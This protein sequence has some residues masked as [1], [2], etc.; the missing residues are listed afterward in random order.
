MTT[1]PDTTQMN[2][3][4]EIQSTTI[5]FDIETGSQ[6]ADILADQIPAFDPAEV[7]TGN[8]KDPALIA[9]KVEQAREKH[10]ADFFAKAA[11]SPAT[12]TVVA[13]GIVVISNGQAQGFTIKFAD[14]DEAATIDTLWELYRAHYGKNVTFVGHNILDFDLPFLVNRSRILGLNLPPRLF[15]YKGGRIYWNDIFVDTRVLWLLGRKPTDTVS[16]LDHCA[17]AFGLGKKTGSGADFA[18]LAIEDRPAASEYL[19]Q[20]LSLTLKLATRLGAL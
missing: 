3:T 11:L 12:G 18:R 14:G 7:K 1:S 9:A 6:P 17:G 20:D 13:I 8:L 15:S 10:Q 16:N 2:P 5:I 19:T 4:A